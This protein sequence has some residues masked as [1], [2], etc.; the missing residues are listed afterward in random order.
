MPRSRLA[1]LIPN[2]LTVSRLALG[3]AFP[4]LPPEWRI[5][6]ALYAAASDLL[7]GAAGRLLGAASDAGRVLDPLADKV[8]AAGVVATLLLDGL[9]GAGELLLITLRDLAVLAGA[10]WAAAR[11]RWSVFR[12]MSP[13]LLGKAT[14]AAQFTLFLALLVWEELPPALLAATASIS[15]LAALEYL[16]IYF[17]RGRR[18]T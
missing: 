6:V 10:G 14:T 11:G 16:H 7:D 17:R 13:T 3:A 1:L 4:W 5:G 18:V 2:S 15:F 12:G 8:F 9:L